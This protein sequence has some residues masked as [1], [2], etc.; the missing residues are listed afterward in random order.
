MTITLVYGDDWS[1]LYVDG[2]LKFQNHRI[3]A[4]D[5]LEALGLSFEKKDAGEF[6]MIT[7]GLPEDLSE[8][9][10]EDEKRSLK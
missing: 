7:G 2:K 1:G 10:F 3:E 5:V 8:V 9:K 6:L 4:D